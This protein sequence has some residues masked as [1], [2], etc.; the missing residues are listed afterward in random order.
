V[1]GET[2]LAGVPFKQKS[3]DPFD[4]PYGPKAVEWL[5]KLAECTVQ[6]TIVSPA[7]VASSLEQLF[8]QFAAIYT[9]EPRY[10]DFL[11]GQIKRIRQ[12]SGLFSTVFQHGDPGT[13]NAIITPEDEVTFLDWEAAEP[14]GIP[15]WDLF[16]FLRSYTMGAAPRLRHYD[17]IE[18]FRRQF[19]D[20]PSL[21]SMVMRSVEQYCRRIDLSGELIEP[22]FYTCWM[23]RS[24]KQATLLPKHKLSRGHYL[25]LL[26]LCIDLRE[27]PTFE[28]LFEIR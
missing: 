13:W 3:R 6:K 5:T 14:Q 20:N 8:E 12:F 26:Q 11:A 16:Y 2:I 1:L 27:N 23:H 22:L 18:A 7:Q 10:L 9:V 24:L 19:I 17:R 28:H 15:L 25:N 4:S 21:A